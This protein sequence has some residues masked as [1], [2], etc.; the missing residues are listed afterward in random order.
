MNLVINLLI[1]ISFWTSLWL[2]LSYISYMGNDW[3]KM[4]KGLKFKTDA[5]F[6]AFLMVTDWTIFFM[7]VR[8]F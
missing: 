7:L 1:A 6:V 3:Y 2:T 4:N 8:N 5:A